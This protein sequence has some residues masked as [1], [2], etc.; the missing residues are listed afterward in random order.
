MRRLRAAIGGKLVG[1]G[2]V[3]IALRARLRRDHRDPDRAFLGCGRLG[4]LHVLRVV[5]L[6]HE[7]AAVIG[8]FEDHRLAGEVR[9]LDLLARRCSASVNA[10]AASP[11]GAALAVE[12]TRAAAVSTA[13]TAAAGHES[14]P[15][16]IEKV[17]LLLPLRCL[18]PSRVNPSLSRSGC[19]ADR[20]DHQPRASEPAA[21]PQARPL[22]P[23]RQDKVEPR[24]DRVLQ[25]LSAITLSRFVQSATRNATFVSAK[26]LRTWP[27]VDGGRLVDLAGDAPAGGEVDEDHPAFGLELGDSLGRPGLVGR[28]ASAAGCAARR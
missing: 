8:P 23:D 26:A 9:Q 27:T 24:P 3:G 14:N 10:G 7:R 5:V 25:G 21:A 15:V 12:T 11:G 6:L 1:A 2:G 28:L 18:N 13:A 22:R 19:L 16:A 20:L 4:L 17:H